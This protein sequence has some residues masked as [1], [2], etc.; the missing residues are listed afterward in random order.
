MVGDC[1]PEKLE[2]ACYLL[3]PEGQNLST[4]L[5]KSIFKEMTLFTDHK[6][7]EM[8]DRLVSHRMIKSL[9]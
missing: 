4:T 1:L 9:N 2:K 7:G 3:G 5:K 8:G 6:N